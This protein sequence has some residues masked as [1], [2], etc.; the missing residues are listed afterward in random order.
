MCWRLLPQ[1][2]PPQHIHE[3]PPPSLNPE[4]APRQHFRRT[5]HSDHG[6]PDVPA[7]RPPRSCDAPARGVQKLTE[8]LGRADALQNMHKNKNG[9]VDQLSR[10]QRYGGGGGGGDG[11]SDEDNWRHSKIRRK[12]MPHAETAGRPC[13]RAGQRTRAH[14]STRSFR[15]TTKM[16]QR[17]GSAAHRDRIQSLLSEGTRPRRPVTRR[18]PRP[19]TTAPPA[20]LPHLLSPRARPRRAPRRRVP[21]GICRPWGLRG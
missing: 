10:V 15:F 21:T 3:R 9:L 5:V 14:H 6:R 20:S 13:S 2:P 12:S 7:Q 11:G 4:V 8:R 16:P 19:R 1:V 18:P 17:R